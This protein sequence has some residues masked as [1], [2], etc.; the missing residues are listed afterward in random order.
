MHAHAE[1]LTAPD[2][3]VKF[4]AH[5]ARPGIYKGWGQFQ[6]QGQVFAIPFTLKAD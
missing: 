1:T 6:R 5:I 2:G 3:Q 4:A